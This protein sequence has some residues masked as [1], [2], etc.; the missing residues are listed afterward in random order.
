MSVE[1]CAELSFVL[2]S[3]HQESRGWFLLLTQRHSRPTT[4]SVGITIQRFIS[5]VFSNQ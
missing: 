5:Y 3:L 1:G 2:V 4:T